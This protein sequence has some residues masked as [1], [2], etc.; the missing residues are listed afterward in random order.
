MERAPG[1]RVEAIAVL[2]REI[3][4]QNLFRHRIEPEEVQKWLELTHA[5]GA[6]ILKKIMI[7][8]LN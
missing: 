2:Q 1:F 3:L 5:Q 7:A 6:E 4:S 8:V